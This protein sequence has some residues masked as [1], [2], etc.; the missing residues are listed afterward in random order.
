MKGKPHTSKAGRL[1]TSGDEINLRPPFPQPFPHSVLSTLCVDSW[2]TEVSITA[3]SQLVTCGA[4]V[5]KET[6][7]PRSFLLLQVS[8]NHTIIF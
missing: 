4:F 1:S 8:R 6:P 7:G 3:C 2:T 5:L